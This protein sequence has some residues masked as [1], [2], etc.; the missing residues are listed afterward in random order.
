MLKDGE[1]IG[2]IAIYRQ[3]VRTFEDRKIELFRSF[4]AQAV[5]AIENA[6]LLTE[7]RQRTDDLSE[8][9]MWLRTQPTRTRLLLRRSAASE[10]S[11]AIWRGTPGS[12][13][14]SHG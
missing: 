2:A 5:I 14:R 1:V 10:R 3:E 9:L 13:R 12:W 7:L 11:A 6:R 8:A 4:A